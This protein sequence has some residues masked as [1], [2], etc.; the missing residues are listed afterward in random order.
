MHYFKLWE[1]AQVDYLNIARER[2]LQINLLPLIQWF[3][4][5]EWKWKCEE[6]NDKGEDYKNCIHWRALH[7]SLDRWIKFTNY[8]FHKKI[9]ITNT[10]KIESEEGVMKMLINLNE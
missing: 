8:F 6:L 2:K 4:P 5:I 7:Q 10:K 9:N 3:T 1:Q